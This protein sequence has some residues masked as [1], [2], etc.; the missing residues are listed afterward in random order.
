MGKA[1]RVGVGR[2]G[3]AGVARDDVRVQ[4]AVAIAALDRAAGVRGALQA[5]V[6]DAARGGD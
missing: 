6:D 5:V 1:R 3:Q 4:V 2:T